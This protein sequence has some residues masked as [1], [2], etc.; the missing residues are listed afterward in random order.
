MREGSWWR[1]NPLLLSLFRA[2]AKMSNVVCN[3]FTPIGL[4]NSVKRE[5]GASQSVT[6][7]E[8]TFR[9]LLESEAKRSERSGY[10]CR[11][12]F[13]Y[14]SDAH[15][16]RIAKMDSHAAKTV[17]AALSGCLRETDYIGWYRE[18]LVAGGVLTVV[19]RDAASDVFGR[20]QRDLAESLRTELGAE[21]ASRFEIRVLRHDELAHNELKKES[22]VVN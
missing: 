19:G 10:F 14:R 9:Y 15:G 6:Y 17:M 16:R 12:L 20:L 11:V 4:S 1:E 21:E 18:G 3:V 2:S 5:N 8:E 7:N 22:F 13:V